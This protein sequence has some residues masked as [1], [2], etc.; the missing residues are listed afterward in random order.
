MRLKNFFT[1]Y[2]LHN[3]L[4]IFTVDYTRANTPS[5]SYRDLD[6]CSHDFSSRFPDVY[7]RG[8]IIIKYRIE[9]AL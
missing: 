5:L 4:Y 1:G 7:S 8:S 9:F 3:V 6:A 2:W